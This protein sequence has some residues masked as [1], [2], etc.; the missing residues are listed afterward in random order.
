MIHYLC[1]ASLAAAVVISADKTDTKTPDVD[2]AKF[3]EKMKKKW[4]SI[5]E[6]HP[7]DFGTAAPEGLAAPTALPEQHILDTLHD[8]DTTAAPTLLAAL[9]DLDVATT[10]A[11]QTKHPTVEDI[12]AELAHLKAKL[13]ADAE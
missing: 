11:P 2:L 6:K 13:N 5:L 10:A 8:L 7:I 12:S 3:E 4:D 9:D 1:F